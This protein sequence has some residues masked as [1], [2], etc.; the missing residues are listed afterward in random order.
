MKPNKKV[1]LYFRAGRDQEEEFLTAQS[2]FPTSRSRVGLTDSLVVGRYSVLPFYRELEEDLKLQGSKLINSYMEH[3]YI[4]SFDWYYDVM[5][6]TP[7]SYFSLQ[8]VPK[9]KG[10]FIVKGRTNSR[11]HQWNQMMFAKNWEE[12]KDISFKLLDDPL[13]GPQGLVFRDYIPLESFGEGVTGQPFANEWR[14]FFYKGKLLTRGYYWI[15]GDVIPPDS[16]FDSEAEAFAQQV[17]DILK[18]RT[19]FFVIDIA[20]T[21]K[22]NWTLIEV[23]D[24]Q[25][26]G[27]SGNDAKTLYENLKKA[28]EEE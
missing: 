11:K 25:Q 20:K 19:T 6:L 9:N 21:K 17:A 3:D 16:V 28:I 23:N 26:S 5:D 10:P 15:N 4:A 14:C 2:I 12:A 18:E 7:R 13:I 22:G 8:D 24:G 1:S 27:L